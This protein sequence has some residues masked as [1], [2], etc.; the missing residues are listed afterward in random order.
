MIVRV[1]RFRSAIL[2]LLWVAVTYFFVF[3]AEIHVNEAPVQHVL[4]GLSLLAGIYSI[5]PFLWRT[6]NE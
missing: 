5:R 6:G 4:A 1:T 2:G 3:H